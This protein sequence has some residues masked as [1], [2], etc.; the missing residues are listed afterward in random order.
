MKT[1]LGADICHN[2]VV[3]WLV[4]SRP[5]NPKAYWKEA[6]K[7]RDRD[8]DKDCLTF[9]YNDGG[10]NQM[11]Q[12]EFDAIALEPTGMHYSN[13]VA[14]VARQHGK[15][16][17]WVGH[18]EAS[19]HRKSQ[20]LPDK[21]DLADS[22][23]LGDYAFLYYG[24]E[25]YFIEFEPFP[26][27]RI[28]EIYLQLKTLNRCQTPLLAR[29]KQQLAHEFPEAM[30]TGIKPLS[31]GRR[32][33]LCW[34]AE[35]DRGIARGAK[36][37]DKRYRTSVSQ[38]YNIPISSYTRR[39]A[40]MADDYDQFIHDLETE[41]RSLV[42]DPLFHQYNKVFDD[43]KFGLI[44]RAVLLSLIYPFEK[45]PTIGAFKQ[46]LGAG[47]VEHSSGDTSASGKGG[48][49]SFCRSEMYLW[50]YT[51][52]GN[53]N[54]PNSRRPNSTVGKIIGAKYDGWWAKYHTDNSEHLAKLKAETTRRLNS[55][56]DSVILKDLDE[57]LTKD[58]MTKLLAR[59]A[60]LKASLATE[61]TL[62]TD[63][64]NKRTASKKFGQLVIGKT[65]GFTARLLYRS[66]RDELR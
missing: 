58:G 48:G 55:L 13:L 65:I 63:D 53:G 41:L 43:Y 47:R 29:I 18:V 19:N 52:I 8:P 28:K 16:I 25:G 27:S 30:D 38:T 62:E 56:L 49:S 39:L 14:E 7:L 66:L 10:I 33:L 3:C 32:T 59:I 61:G 37:W 31:D 9:Y 40:G 36:Y 57:I 6:V 1:I 12:L 23:A 21:N 24:Q 22:Y 60:K 11:M 20:K 46:R 45:F 5:R 51:V 50:V 26:V 4:N 54:K 42:N 44:L 17:L 15:E 34:L 35:R 2:R 64:I